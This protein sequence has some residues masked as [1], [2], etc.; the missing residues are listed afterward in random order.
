MTHVQ[1]KLVLGCLLKTW[2]CL[3]GRIYSPEKH[4]FVDQFMQIF[5]NINYDDDIDNGDNIDDGDNIDY[6]RW[7]TKIR[8]FKS[9]KCFF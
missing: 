9:I 7:D 2:L 1:S 3:V 6:R 8:F 5:D 4:I